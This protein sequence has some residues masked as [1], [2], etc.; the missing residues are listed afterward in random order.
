MKKTRLQTVN[1]SSIA[2]WPLGSKQR[3]HPP[4]GCA[5][6]LCSRIVLFLL[7]KVK[8]FTSVETDGVPVDFKFL[9]GAVASFEFL[10]LK[11]RNTTSRTRLSLPRIMI[12]DTYPKRKKDPPGVTK[13]ER[14]GYIH[15]FIASPAK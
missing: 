4:P 1:L 7:V 14:G 5:S 10:T 15:S 13:I 2:L 9:P 8:G 6:L 11:S 3:E 12:H